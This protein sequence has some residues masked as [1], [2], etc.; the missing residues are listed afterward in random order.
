MDL[1]AEVLRE[2]LILSAN[3]LQSIE[4]CLN[5][6]ALGEPLSLRRLLCLET[7]FSELT[8]K[9]SSVVFIAV[10][11]MIQHMAPVLQAIGNIYPLSKLLLIE[12]ELS[13]SHDLFYHFGWQPS[14]WRFG[15][16]A[17]L[18]AESQGGYCCLA[19]HIGFQAGPEQM[20]LHWYRPSQNYPAGHLGVTSRIRL[21][22][23]VWRYG[24]VRGYRCER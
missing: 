11:V 7:K 21:L 18:C 23:T 24:F 12:R 3:H 15:G 1:K 16:I 8:F 19:P 10:L 6:A 14:Y 17:I 5:L 2:Y 4:S 20:S 22:E 13:V 9:F